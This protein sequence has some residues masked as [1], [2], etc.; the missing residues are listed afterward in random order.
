MRWIDQNGNFFTPPLI[1]DGMAHH[2]PGPEL[3]LHAGY[4]PYTPEYKPPKRV[5]KFD[6]YKVILALGEAWTTW[7]AKLEEQGLYDAF[8]AA[9]YLSLGDPLFVKVWAKLTPEER[10]KLIRECRYGVATSGGM[11][12]SGGMVTSGGI[13]TSGG[14]L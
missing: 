13:V 11:I 8:M 14:V 6:R 12:T 9:P 10:T 1:V 2:S 5:L 7:K 4:T 3:L